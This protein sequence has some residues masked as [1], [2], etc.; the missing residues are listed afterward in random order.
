MDVSEHVL[1][2]RSKSH[3]M[4]HFRY[5][6]ELMQFVLVFFLRKSAGIY[7]IY[8]SVEV[9]FSFSEIVYLYLKFGN[10]LHGC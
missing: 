2:N 1:V 6:Y 7:Y 10:S 4:N 8:L 3:S 5:P 9:F